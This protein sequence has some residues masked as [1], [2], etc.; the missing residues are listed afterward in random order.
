[1]IKSIFTII[2]ISLWA[3]A[4]S[5]T[6]FIITKGASADGSTMMVY[7][8]DGEWLYH[9]KMLSAASHKKGQTIKF[10]IPG[11]DSFLEIPQASE[12]YKRLGF[13]MNEHQ[14]AIGE[15]T[16]TGR[17]ELWN[18]KLPLKYWHL[19]S[20]ALDRSKT[21]REAIEVITSLVETYGDGSEGESFSI[22]DPNEAWILEMIGTGDEKTRCPLGSNENP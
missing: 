11:T 13:H 18:K 9:L 17:E 15:T 19:M 20:L 14:V 16:F 5:C 1:M 2:F 8:N 10:K 12:T 6:N 7:T 4:F 21:A 3:S 22:V